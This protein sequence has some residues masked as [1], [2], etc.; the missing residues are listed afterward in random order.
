VHVKRASLLLLAP[1]A[2]LLLPAAGCFSQPD[3]QGGGRL[4]TLPGASDD[5]GTDGADAVFVPDT[6]VAPVDA[7]GTGGG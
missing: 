7:A 2:L 5:G 3:Y 4:D 6:F 1:L